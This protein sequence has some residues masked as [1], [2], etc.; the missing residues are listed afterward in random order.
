M[1]FIGPA[2]VEA[3]AAK[4]PNDYGQYLRDLLND[5]SSPGF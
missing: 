4:L 1:G 3:L 5:P 2:Q